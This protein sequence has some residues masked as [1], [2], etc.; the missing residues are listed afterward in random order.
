M[1]ICLF[2]ISL[3]I[4]AH[5][6]SQQTNFNVTTFS[7]D[8][9]ALQTN[10]MDS[11]GYHSSFVWD[12][13]FIEY[14]LLQDGVRKT[15]LFHSL[16]QINDLKAVE[17]YNKIYLPVYNQQGLLNIQARVIKDGVVVFEADKDDIKE[18]QEE[19]VTY[20]LIALE[21]VSPGCFVESILGLEQQWDVVDM[22]VVQNSVPTKESVTTIVCPEHFHFKTKIYNGSG[23]EQDT[24]VSGRR[25]ISM[26]LTNLPAGEDEPYCYPDAHKTRIEALLQSVDGATYKPEKWADMGSAFFQ[27]VMEDYAVNEKAA[28]KILKEAGVSDKNTAKQ[29]IFAIENYL[30]QNLAIE[31]GAP[32]EKM[33]SKSMSL[34]YISPYGLNRMYTMLFQA[35]EIPYEVVGT[36]S[37]EDKKFD[38]EFENSDSFSQIVF[39]M[40]DIKAY[41][42]P[43]L[44]TDRAP[45]IADKFLGQD[46]L[47][48]KPVKLG[49]AIS[50]VTTI[51]QVAPNKLEET[52]MGEEYVLRFSPDMQKTITDYKKSYS[53]LSGYGLR[54]ACYFIKG[55]D[56]K[57]LLESF[58]K[59]DYEN[60]ELGPI[61]VQNIDISNQ[62]EYEKPFIMSTTITG[63]DLLEFAGDKIIVKL[64]EIIGRQNEMY[65]EKPR[66]WGIDLDH[67][68]EYQRTIT[69][70]IPEGYSVSGE[71]GIAMDIQC[72]DAS[73]NSLCKFV[74]SYK[75]E[76]NNL[77]VTVTETY[78]ALEI[79]IEYYPGFVEVVNAAADFNKVS[80]VLSK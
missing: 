37:R 40:P 80:L 52:I 78:G 73:G 3:F 31:R 54:G 75:M 42:D 48:I 12:N 7:F 68:H 13:T 69:F 66:Q 25:F 76:G 49:D 35:A 64:G 71:E 22:V 63:T 72:N 20:N 34:K 19:D 79:P 59:G 16:R 27:R 5:C 39:Y 23:M 57:E 38:K 43:Q 4:S 8:A 10:L 33:I 65:N 1:R 67:L 11:T 74:S 41:L 36:C 28:K 9:A 58:I 61:E 60:S 77:V 56:R 18:V 46:G 32:F 14:Q 21:N 29:N 47:R 50:G 6:F 51:K 53:G 15:Q 30:K 62:A 26:R 45:I 55:E 17:D 2:A 24:V 70:E 44:V